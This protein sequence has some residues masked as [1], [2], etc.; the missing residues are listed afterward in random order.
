MNLA[1]NQRRFAF[2]SAK[3][4]KMSGTSIYSDENGTEFEVT[5]AGDSTTSSSLWDDLIKL[6]TVGMLTYVR[7]GGNS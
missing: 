4:A 1:S 2:Y 5:E 3:H 7:E 6:P